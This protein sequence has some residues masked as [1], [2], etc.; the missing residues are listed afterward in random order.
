MVTLL[1]VL[2]S[3]AACGFALLAWTQHREAARRS[4]ARVAALAAAIDGGEPALASSA[5]LDA[6]TGEPTAPLF[7]TACSCRR[8][9]G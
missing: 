8:V 2:A 9:A 1:A 4:A 6:V 5:S 3:V 7:A